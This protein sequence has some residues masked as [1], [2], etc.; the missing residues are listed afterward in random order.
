MGKTD[1]AGAKVII[2]RVQTWK[3]LTPA[4][5]VLDVTETQ[6]RRHLR[7]GKDFSRSLARRML[8]RGVVVE[9]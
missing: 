4:A 3:N 7:G 8:E 2:R 6:V 1:T 9:R 5:R